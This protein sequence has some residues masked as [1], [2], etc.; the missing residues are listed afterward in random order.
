MEIEIIDKKENK[1]LFRTEY[2]AKLLHIKEA[3]PPRVDT[4][5]KLA[6]KVNADADRTAVI[7]IDSEYGIGSSNVIFHV[8][9]DSKHM[10]AVENRHI[11]KRNGFITEE[12]G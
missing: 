2:S 7:K 10:N 1:L 5:N 11:L 9:D 8:Y 4:K 3:T 12:S 6:A